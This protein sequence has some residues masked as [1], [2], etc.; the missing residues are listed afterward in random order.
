MSGALRIFSPIG[1]FLIVEGIFIAAPVAAT[2]VA[3]LAATDSATVAATDAA[4]VASTVPA[5]AQ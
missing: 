5:K 3:P 4:T 2:F 1:D